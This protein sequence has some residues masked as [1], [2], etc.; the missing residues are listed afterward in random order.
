MQ[1]TD[2]RKL[3]S[4]IM[5]IIRDS[6]PNGVRTADIDRQIFPPDGSPHNM[7]GYNLIIELRDEGQIKPKPPGTGSPWVLA[8]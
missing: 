8:K 3:K 6:H 5:K 7:R 4:Q 2:N 1:M